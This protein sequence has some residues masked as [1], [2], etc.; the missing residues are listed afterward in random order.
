M[1]DIRKKGKEFGITSN[2]RNK[3]PLVKEF[4]EFIH[5][6]SSEFDFKA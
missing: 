4:G 1:I 3:T 2:D 6:K 5:I